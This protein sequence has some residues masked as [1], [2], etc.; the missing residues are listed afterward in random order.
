MID[1][2]FGWTGNKQLVGSS[3]AGAK[4][5]APGDEEPAG[6]PQGHGDELRRRKP[7]RRWA[8]RELPD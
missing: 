1:R 6:P 2:V 4:V 7:A 5:K 3:Y 8:T